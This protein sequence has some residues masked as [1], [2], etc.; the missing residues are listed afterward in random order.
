MQYIFYTQFKQ[1]S[2]IYTVVKIKRSLMLSNRSSVAVNQRRTDNITGQKKTD[3]DPQT[4]TQKNTNLTKKNAGGLRCSGRVSMPFSASG[5]RRVIFVTFRWKVIKENR[6]MTFFS[7]SEAFWIF[8]TELKIEKYIS[9]L[10][11]NYMLNFCKFRC[12]GHRLPVE[13]GRWHNASR[14]DRVC[15]LCDSSDIGDGFHYL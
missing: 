12:G 5:T 9:I 7:A 11:Y 3:S 8:K 1:L 6:R 14:A 15:H 13:T 2:F 4:S 10:P